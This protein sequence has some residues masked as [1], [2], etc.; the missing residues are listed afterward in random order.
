MIVSWP[1]SD[2]VLRTQLFGY[3]G[4]RAFQRQHIAG[5]KSHPSGVF[6]ESIEAFVY[7]VLHLT[8]FDARYGAGEACLGGDCKNGSLRSLRAVDDVIDVGAALCVLAVGNHYQ[9]TPA[10]G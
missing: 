7:F 1:V 2:Q 4:E 8:R 3:F 10:L 9:R 5:E 6:A